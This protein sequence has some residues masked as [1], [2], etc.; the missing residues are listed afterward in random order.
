MGD[1]LSAILE[2]LKNERARLSEQREAVLTTINHLEAEILKVDSAVA[3]L[4]GEAKPK[5]PRRKSGGGGLKGPQILALTERVLKD[6]GALT[7]PK[8]REKVVERA[9]QEGNT[10]KGIPLVLPKVLKSGPF[11]FNGAK[12]KLPRV[13]ALR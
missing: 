1:K 4:L 9:I 6:H 8:L 2:Q 12:W 13:E 10:A 3:A 7:Q 11:D 5:R